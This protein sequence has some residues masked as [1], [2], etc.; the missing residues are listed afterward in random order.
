MPIGMTPFE[1][2]K[3]E[4]SIAH[5]TH[6][7]SGFTQSQSGQRDEPKGMPD[8]R[9]QP[10]RPRV[11]GCLHVRTIRPAQPL[12]GS[13]GWISQIFMQNQPLARVKYA[14]AAIEFIASSVGRTGA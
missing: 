11:A 9:L 2:G 4:I 7:R 12:D 6:C 14:W 10:H 13:D 3:Y 5:G 8:P 1:W